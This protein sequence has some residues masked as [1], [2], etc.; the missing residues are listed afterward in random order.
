MDRARLEA[1]L[2]SD[3][4]CVLRVYLDSEGYLTCGIGHLVLAEDHLEE[5]QHI[6]AAQCQAFFRT[7]VDTAIRICQRFFP[8]WSVFPDAVQEVLANMA[9]S[10]GMTRRSRIVR[11]R[12]AIADQDYA[13]AANEMVDSR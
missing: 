3:E 9:F 4:G 7:E 10:R 8:Q 1:Q 2:I 6:T 12:A 13:T 5:G 11:M